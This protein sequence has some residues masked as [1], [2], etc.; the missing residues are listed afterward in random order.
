MLI[1]ISLSVFS[2]AYMHG[3]SFGAQRAVCVPF[4]FLHFVYSFGHR[5][6]VFLS[7]SIGDVLS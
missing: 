3:L 2:H 6:C 7:V 5:L 4:I 1:F